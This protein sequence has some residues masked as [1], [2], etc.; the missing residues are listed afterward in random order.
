MSPKLKTVAAYAL[1]TAL[2]YKAFP[3]NPA[4]GPGS[5]NGAVKIIESRTA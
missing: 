4:R 5:G 2:P 1:S 3:P